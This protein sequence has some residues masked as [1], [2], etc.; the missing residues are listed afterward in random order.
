MIWRVSKIKKRIQF[1]SKKTLQPSMQ[2]RDHTHNICSIS[3]HKK[4]LYRKNGE[5]RLRKSCRK[6]CVSFYG[7]EMRATLH[8]TRSSVKKWDDWPYTY[9][10]YFPSFYFSYFVIS[11]KYLAW[12]KNFQA[13]IRSHERAIY[14]IMSLS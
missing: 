13:R 7:L 14:S 6:I 1:S 5:K 10:F 3:Q 12:E 8:C 11:V 2:L 4:M 9:T